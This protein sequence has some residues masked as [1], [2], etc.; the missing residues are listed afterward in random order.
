MGSKPASA[1][2]VPFAPYPELMSLG[3]LERGSE[4]GKLKHLDDVTNVVR[5]DVSTAVLLQAPR[6]ESRPGGGGASGKGDWTGLG[7]RSPDA[8]S[9][10]GPTW[11]GVGPPR[12]E[13]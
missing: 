5:R 8:L 2:C 6:G 7:R 4:P 1:L 13:S 3:F 12:R 11:G 9:P 10:A